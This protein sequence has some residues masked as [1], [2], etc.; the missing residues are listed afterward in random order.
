M[1]FL[2][3][4]P[5]APPRLVLVDRAPLVVRGTGFRA[6]ERVAIVVGTG[7]LPKLLKVTAVNGAFRATVTV[8]RSSGCG[9]ATFVSARG[10]RGSVA[11]LR[12]PGTPCVPPPRD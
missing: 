1:A 2:P 12:L 4:G 6:G 11:V 8:A 10:N 7:V 3:D 9:A 5:P